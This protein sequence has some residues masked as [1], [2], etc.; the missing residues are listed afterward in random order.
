MISYL[1][2]VFATYGTSVTLITDEGSS[3]TAKTV[4]FLF[5]LRIDRKTLSA[6]KENFYETWLAQNTRSFIS[7]TDS[8]MSKLSALKDV[9]E[10]SFGKWYFTRIL[11][12]ATSP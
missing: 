12:Q 7:R 2:D 11:N 9:I 1:K 3:F 8:S 5:L 6:R 4:S 10:L